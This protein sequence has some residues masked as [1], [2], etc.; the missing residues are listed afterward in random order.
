MQAT[1]RNDEHSVY[2]CSYNDFTRGDTPMKNLTLANIA[3]ACQ[4]VY[5]GDS[6]LLDKEV[7]GVTIDRIFSL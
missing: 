6:S 3:E 1:Y 5:H 2:D 7:A 4:G